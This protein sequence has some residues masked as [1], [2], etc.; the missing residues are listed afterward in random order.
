VGLM[1]L[2]QACAAISTLPPAERAVS[3]RAL[4]GATT[5]Q[6]SDGPDWSILDPLECTPDRAAHCLSAGNAVAVDNQVCLSVLDRD[7]ACPFGARGE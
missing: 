6:L 3:T 4:A 1:S 2:E 7:L 5:C